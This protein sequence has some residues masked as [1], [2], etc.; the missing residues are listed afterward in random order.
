MNNK[1][2][3]IEVTQEKVG[4]RLLVGAA[5]SDSER[6]FTLSELLIAMVVFTLIIGSVAM[7]VG[8]SQAIF[9]TEQG[10]SEMDQ[11]A[12]LLID[13]MTR[14]IQQSKENALGLGPKFRSIYSYNAP[15]GKTDEVTIVSAETDTKIPS[16]ALPMLPGSNKDFASSDHYVELLPNTAAGANAAQVVNS[17]TANEEFIVS[18]TR[19]DGSVQFDFIVAKGAKITPDGLIGL[20]FATT[21]HKGITP[22]VKFG[23]TY[24]SGNFAVRPVTIKRYF[25]DRTESKA[26]PTFSLQINE[27]QPIAISRNVVAFQLRYL[28][29]RDGETD[30]QWSK[31]QNISRDYKTIALEVTMTARTELK[32]DP[33]AERLVTL[34]S[35]VRPRQTPG[36]GY[37]SSAGGGGGPSSPGLPG[38]GGSNGG[39]G[40]NGFPGGNGSGSPNGFGPG[41]GNGDP[42]ADGA[43]GNGA[44]GDDTG[45]F[46]SGGYNRVSRQIGKQPKLGERLNPRP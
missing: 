5:V 44:Y 13:F 32:S 16:L 40:G 27:G 30:G 37:G 18:S 7:L 9:R 22:E 38:D 36:G 43:G 23:D 2:D 24:E 10:V 17:I 46:R 6:G 11:N 15:D 35:V 39:G 20:S 31:Q 34:A 8:K 3:G 4:P 19:A 25:V 28:E 45:G 1:I 12:R 26:N 21:E 29:V 41:G 42:F 14:D 33:T